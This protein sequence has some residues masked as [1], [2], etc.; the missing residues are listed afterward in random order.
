[1][2]PNSFSSVYR[3]VMPSV[4]PGVNCW[5]TLGCHDILERVA[6]ARTPM[7]KSGE[8]MRWASAGKQAARAVR[9]NAAK[10]AILFT[11]CWR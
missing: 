8:Y 11:A 6:P 7:A 4:A 1:M 9:V 2:R 10:R 3:A 5:R